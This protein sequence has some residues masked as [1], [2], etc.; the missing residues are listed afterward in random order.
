MRP[1]HEAL[2][3]ESYAK[4]P[5]SQC[6]ALHSVQIVLAMAPPANPLYRGIGGAA[7][8]PITRIRVVT[9]FRSVRDMLIPP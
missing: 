4:H 3:D 6:G 2:S 9:Y 1:A 7:A 8:K 5:V